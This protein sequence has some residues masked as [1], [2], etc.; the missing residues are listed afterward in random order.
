MLSNGNNGQ[1]YKDRLKVADVLLHYGKDLSQSR[2]GLI[3]SPFRDERTP[4][5]HILSNGYAWKDFG[6]GSGGGV[7]DLVMR[8][9]NC[10]RETAIGRL[11]EM[12]T[13]GAVFTADPFP[14]R[15][16]APARR[17][18][19][20]VYSEEPLSSEQFTSYAASR[21][22]SPEILSAYCREV[23]VRRGRSFSTYIGFP[24]SDGGYVLRSPLPGSDGKR[25][26]SAYPPFIGTDGALCR[27][28]SA[29]RVA[30]FE[31]FFDFM[32][33]LQ[34]CGRTVPDC[35]A[36]VLNSVTNLDKALPFILAHGYVELYLDNDAA[37]RKASA[38]IARAMESASVP[39]RVEDLSHLY[40]EYN[41][42][43]DYLKANGNTPF[44][45]SSYGN[46]REQELRE[47]GDHL[48]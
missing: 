9:E 45:L 27:A 26:T 38:E 1:P 11:R 31:G 16:Q 14:E 10:G 23:T 22:I 12:R 20:S 18:S 33:L 40:R 34:L 24:N 32:S 46:T 30:V 47:E 8:L 19:L 5:F 3:R 13:G 4:S 25:C 7:I 36:C 29:G 17:P 39:G 2:L 28:P 15:R 35:D 6:D 42:V 48:P 41:D 37:G 43:N 21:G 44:K